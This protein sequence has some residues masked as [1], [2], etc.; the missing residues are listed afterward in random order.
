MDNGQITR[1]LSL[2]VCR[3][4]LTVPLPHVA[5]LRSLRSKHAVF[6]AGKLEPGNEECCSPATGSQFDTLELRQ[7]PS[8]GHGK[9]QE[10]RGHVEFVGSGLMER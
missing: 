1:L 5:V 6:A 4:V 10:C 7:S 2:S 3:L 8:V 9:E